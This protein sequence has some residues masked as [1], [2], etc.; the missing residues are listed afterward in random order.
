M[1]R[2]KLAH[3]TRLTAF[4]FV[5]CG[6][7]AACFPGFEVAGSDASANPDGSATGTGDDASASSA[8]N[9]GNANATAGNNGSATAGN[10]GSA[11][12]GNNGSATSGNNGTSTAG[13]NGGGDGGLEGGGGLVPHGS[14][15][16]IDPSGGGH[17]TATFTH[18]VIMDIH[19]ITVGQFKAWVNAGK[20]T[21][22][23]GQSLD[24]G[25]PYAG[26]MFWQSAWNNDAAS[27]RY[28][29]TNCDEA[30]AM[31][32]G[33]SGPGQGTDFNYYPTYPST[34]SNAD[35][36]PIV[37][38]NWYQAIAY[39]FWDG[40]KRL[41]TEA[42]YQYEITGRGIGRTYPWG[43]TPMPTDCS[44]AIW[45]GADAGQLNEWNGCGWPRPVGS[46][47]GG[48]SID[49]IEDMQG[50]VEEWI[51]NDENNEFPSQ[52]PAD[53]A[54]PSED[55]GVFTRTA[56]SGS[57]YTDEPDM[58]GTIYDADQATST[59]ADLGIRCVK[60]KL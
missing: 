34:A 29:D 57:F 52:W 24:P 1:R 26:A 56:R 54:G 50:S 16:F 58:H 7:F 2:F 10:N 49:G 9:G 4:A 20:P 25:G 12:A 51:W 47:P 33:G 27:E 55:A 17:T 42:E 36:I 19:E 5:T 23:D 60:T 32:A 8:G 48:K 13:N 38:V 43:D 30:T 6:A 45:R 53:Y 28:K 31:M 3:A 14:F 44:L 37:C 35:Q 59:F 18:D 21:P 41:A 46:A 39:C 11:T 15:T 22:N 40:Q